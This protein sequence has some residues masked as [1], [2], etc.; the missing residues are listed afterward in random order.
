MEIKELLHLWEETA[1]AELTRDVFEVRLPLEEAAK[2][3]ALSELYPR[4][5]LEEIITDLLCAAL[6]EV[7]R[8]LPYVRGNEVVSRDE[9]GD[10]LYEDIGP[11]PRYRTLLQKHLANYRAAD[12]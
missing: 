5:T 11:T 4:R 2:L 7:E 1:K 10:P 6:S 3:K 9:Q 8:T 12:H